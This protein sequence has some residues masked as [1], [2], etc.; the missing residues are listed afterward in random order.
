M[1]SRPSSAV[2][3]AIAAAIIGQIDGGSGAATIKIYTGSMPATPETSITSQTLLATLTC[4]DPS[5]TESGG[6]ITFSAITQDSAADA[7]G[8]A[9]WARMA[10]SS[11]TAVWDFD[12]TAT[13]GGGAIEMNTTAVVSGGP[14]ALSSLTITL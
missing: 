11:G 6:V 3:T 9:A 2:K 13:G 12:V 5:A 10:D 14:V 4:S 8:T 7:T 1:V